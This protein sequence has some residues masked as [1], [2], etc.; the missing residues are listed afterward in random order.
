MLLTPRIT[1]WDSPFLSAKNTGLGNV[2]FQIASCYGIA[3]KTG[4]K[5][6]W[7]NVVRLADKLKDLY[8]Y[9]H[10]T[11]IFRNFLE[12][13]GAN[14]QSVSEG[15]IYNYSSH[16][17]T[18]LQRTDSHIEL[19]GYLE[20]VD[21]FK[22]YKDEISELF[23]ADDK[24]MELI[25]ERHPIL[26]D[27][28]VTTI[29]IHFRGNEYITHPQIGK[30]WDYDFYKKAVARFKG[31]S[32]NPIFLIFSDDMER[33]DFSFLDGAPYIKMS[34]SEDYIDLWC[35]TLC[36]H[37]VVSH[38]TFSFWGAYLNKNPGAVAIYNHKN[39]KKFNCGYSLN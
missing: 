2:M 19:N 4:R 34:N 35:L 27:K 37:N 29:S 16:L 36:K 3:K 30:T 38:S 7:N 9:N 28:H 23:S 22:E 10:K 14:F 21:Y 39:A 12:V 32:E 20:C 5:A 11:T 1:A 33:I 17:I 26:F 24:S 25:K 6:V 13:S 18:T 15:D 31:I 8:D